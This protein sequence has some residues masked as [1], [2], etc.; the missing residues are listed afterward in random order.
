MSQAAR[1]SHTHPPACRRRRS[2]RS[3]VGHRPPD[4]TDWRSLCIGSASRTSARAGGTDKWGPRKLEPYQWWGGRPRRRL[5][6]CTNAFSQV[7]L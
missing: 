2:G 7:A 5:P 3:G 6:H 1:G 4:T